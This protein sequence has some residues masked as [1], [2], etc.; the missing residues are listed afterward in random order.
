VI[1]IL[2][3]IIGCAA[4]SPP[5][6]IDEDAGFTYKSFFGFAEFLTALAPDAYRTLNATM[7]ER[8]FQGSSKVDLRPAAT[9]FQYNQLIVYSSSPAMAACAEAIVASLYGSELAHVARGIDPPPSL[10]D[11]RR[12]DWHHFLLTGRYAELP[13]TVRAYVE[14]RDDARPA[15]S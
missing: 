10:T 11:G 15:C 6:R 4:A 7:A 1:V 5:A 3:T 13:S 9:R 12:T 14:Y 8:G 2:L